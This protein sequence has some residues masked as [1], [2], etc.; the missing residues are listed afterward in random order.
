MPNS[1]KSRPCPIRVQKLFASFN[2]E[3]ISVTIKI[4]QRM[5]RKRKQ[6]TQPDAAATRVVL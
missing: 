3:E 6:M 5:L 4:L 1:S 2:D